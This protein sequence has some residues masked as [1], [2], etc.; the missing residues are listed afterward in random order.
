[1]RF[2]LSAD[3]GK[4]NDYTAIS[5]LEKVYRL[6]EREALPPQMRRQQKD[7]LLQTY[8]LIHLERLPLGTTYPEVVQRLK[9]IM[10]QP[11]LHQETTLILD[12]TGVGTPVVDFVRQE[13]L[14]PVPILITTGDNPKEDDNG[15]K[16]PKKDI[17]HS[18]LL[19]FQQNRLRLPRAHPL[20]EVLAQELV[21]FRAKLNRRTANTSYEAWRE[22]EHDD[23]VLSV[24]M[25]VW[26]ADRDTYYQ[27]TLPEEQESDYD[28]LTWRT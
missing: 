24:A 19:L 1:M 28:P 7:I 8:D 3:L 14:T 16:V 9:T 27:M 25:A 4:V 23:L 10:Q 21:D 15:F 12:S 5:V 18:L 22:Q 11:R 2:F 17:I 13:G 20:V 26:Y 6:K